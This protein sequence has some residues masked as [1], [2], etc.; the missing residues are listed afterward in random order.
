MAAPP[1]RVGRRA[2]LG[3]VAAVPPALVACSRS[4]G[5]APSGAARVKLALDWMPEPEFGGFYAAR[6]GGAFT[7]AG[8]EVEILGGGAGVPVIQQVSTGRVDFGVAGADEVVNA[9][10]RGAD[11]VPVFAELQTSPRGIMVHAASGAKTMADAIA[12][13]AI[14][15][16]PGAPYA[17]FLAK[18]HR[19]DRARVVPYDGGVAR[20]V[21]D[22]T[23]AQQ[24]FVTSEPIAA[25][26]LGSDPK[27]FLVADEGYNPY[28][29]VVTR[30]AL[31]A[32]QPDL[33]RSFVRAAR[34]GWRA[35]LDDPA[36]ANAVMAKL[37]P[38]MP[39][40]T[41]AAVAKVQ[42]PFVETEETKK[43]KLGMMTRERWETLGKQLVDIGLVDKAPPVDAY[44]VAI[45]D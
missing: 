26:K 36:P 40:E 17:L 42:R 41:M 14:A 44:L 7:R 23:F 8:L 39:L 19:F 34:E 5:P 16:E 43:G 1:A 30:R 20:F 12:S 22:K 38:A 11:L 28:S 35:Y 45:G 18:K 6:E 3:L 10:S 32:D 15:M 27:V 33:V 21:A 25:E 4:G 29:V 13:G 24:C 9:I 37:N 31:W 2:F